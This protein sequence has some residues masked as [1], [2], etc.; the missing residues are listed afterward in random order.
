VALCA[1]LLGSACSGGE[2]LGGDAETTTTQLAPPGPPTDACALLD[3]DEVAA[4]APG[5]EGPG[6]GTESEPDTMGDDAVTGTNSGSSGGTPV[7]RYADCSWPAIEHAGVYLTWVQPSPSPS[8]MV[9]LERAIAQSAAPDGQEA[10]PVE[11]DEPGIDAAVLVDDGIVLRVAGVVGGEDLITI[12]VLDP[13]AAEGS[14]EQAALVDA[15]V[16]AARRL[17]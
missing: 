8:A 3:P 7:T 2:E 15:L 16:A 5:S 10:M 13:P 9:W 14:P 11:V 4:V 12:E 1:L 6:E 17:S